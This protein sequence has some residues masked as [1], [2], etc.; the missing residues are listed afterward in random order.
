MR[1]VERRQ[2]IKAAA[3]TLAW[4][5]GFTTLP[6]LRTAY[7]NDYPNR[8]I[9]I[10]VPFA[11]GG[12]VDYIARVT[13]EFLARSNS[14]GQ[15][16]V[17]EN[18]AGAGG[19]TGIEL[20]IKGEPDGYSLLV[21]NDN[22]A[23]APYILGL[24]R[25]YGN[26]LVPI[27]LLGL[28]PLT[29]VT[30]SSLGLKTMDDLVRLLK[31]KPG[32][33]CAT[34]GVGSNQHVVLEWFNQ[35][36]GV[37]LAHVPYRGAGQA[38]NDLIAGHIKV[39]VLG[40]AALLPHHN[41][42]TLRILAQSGEKRSPSLPDIPTLQEAGFRDFVLDGW[43]AAFAPLGTPPAII[44]RLSAEMGKAMRDPTNSA[45]LL[46]TA[47]EPVGGPPEQVLSLL[48]GDDAKYGRLIKE[49]NIKTN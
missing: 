4:A 37:K 27:C 9:R 38:I 49:L 40:P 43:Y 29:F 2:F 45:N 33:G 35:I 25:N 34:A 16:V 10:V 15:Q 14:L 21:A 48:R 6:G 19:A 26:E 24:N 41:A 7:G 32:Q 1:K 13:A 23:S 47:T 20:G 30:H 44:A 36:A 3:G 5:G 12:G 39:G 22:V 31:E 8:P 17:V 42:G 11:P 18:R 46:K 28:T